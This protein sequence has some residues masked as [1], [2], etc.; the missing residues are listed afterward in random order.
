MILAGYSTLIISNNMH[1]NNLYIKIDI[2]INGK[3]GAAYMENY[4]QSYT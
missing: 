4:T 3:Q 2:F 1:I